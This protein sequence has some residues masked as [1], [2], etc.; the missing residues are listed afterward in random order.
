[1]TR[2]ALILAIVGGV[3]TLSAQAPVPTT[4]APAFEVASVRRNVSG[5]PRSGGP[6][7]LGR[8]KPNGIS[9]TNNTLA[10]LIRSAYGVP[11]DR[12]LGGPGWVRTER[13]DVVA[14][15][16][17]EVSRDELHLMLRTLLAERFRLVVSRQQRERD[18]YVLRLNRAD[19]R[20]GPD[21]RKAADDCEATRPSDPIE[22]VR[23]L[24]LPSSGT[25]PSAGGACVTMASV[26]GA[27]ERTLNATIIDETGLTGRWDFVISHAG[28]QS[29]MMMG[30]NRELE[31]RPSIMVAAQ[32]QLGLKVERR[33]EPGFFDVLVIE[34]VE[35]PAPN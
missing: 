11:E 25:G 19:G 27:F 33:R 7:A 32:E 3:T 23:Q 21:L 22:R 30:R 18:A 6:T 26:A 28:L 34:S 13:F 29:G 5:D 15:A 9:Y 17:T 10:M 35:P 4:T 2:A 12:V 1:M 31:E 14:R 8:S 16:A 24:L 20:L